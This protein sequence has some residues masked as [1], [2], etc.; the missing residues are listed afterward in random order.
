VLR[1]GKKSNLI[2]LVFICC[3]TALV[4]QRG[5]ERVFEFVGLSTSA[6]ATALAGSQV[7]AWNDDYAL[8]GGNPALLSEDMSGSFLFQHNFH[9]AGI[10]NG[11]AGYARHFPKLKSTIH[12]GIHYLSYGKFTAADDMGNVEGEFKANEIAINAGIARQLNERMR[13]GFLMRYVQSSLETYQSTGLVMDAGISYQSENGLSHYAFIVRGVGFQFSKYYPE[14]A[15]GKMP[16]DVQIGFS[17]RL[18][19]VPFRLSVLMHDLNRW[20]LRYESPLDEG[21]GLGFGDEEPREPSKFGESV[22]NAFR[23]I[24]IGGE[25]LIGKKE[26]FMLRLGYH[27]QRRKELSVVNLRSLTGFSAG[28]GFRTKIFVLDYGFAVYHQAGST[29]HLG[30]R[31]QIDQLMRKKIID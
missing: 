29:K 5:G 15:K 16:V 30:L 3:S 31:I 21:T 19:Y 12:G 1:P 23:H 25:F 17:K 7:A 11:F 28:V 27:H 14:A 2:I 13:G 24:A 20:D 9:F 4:G 10:D 18:E 6:R 22:D 8:A 26:N